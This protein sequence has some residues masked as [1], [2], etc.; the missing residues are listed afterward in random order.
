MGVDWVEMIWTAGANLSYVRFGKAARTF[1]ILRMLRLLRLARM[2][3]LM[4]LIIERIRSEQLVIFIDILQ[5][6]V[7]IM[8]MAHLVACVWYGIAVG[9][10]DVMTP[11]GS[12]HHGAPLVSVAVQRRH[13][14][15][16]APELRRAHLHGGRV[17]FLI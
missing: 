13:G 14:R 8:G 12:I 15:N 3:E 1:R 16:H 2:R 9:N 7:V 6:I 11:R 17:P 5:I 4:K 10:D